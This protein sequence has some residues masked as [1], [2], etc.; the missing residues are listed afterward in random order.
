MRNI[1]RGHDAPVAAGGFK[2]RFLL[3]LSFIYAFGGFFLFLALFVV[4][5]RPLT[6]DYSA[7][8][9]ALRHLASFILPVIAFAGLVYILL[10]C[11]ATAVL[12][13]YTLHKI[14]GPLYRMERL[15]ESYLAGEPVKPAFFREGDQ[16]MALASAFNGFIGCLREDRQKWLGIMGHAERLCIQ[17]RETCR[18]EM[19][20]ALAELEIL[21][22]KYR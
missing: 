4:F 10:V 11:M 1:L 14:A 8:F 5:S 13:V 19:E 22:A 2:I 9:F 20:K 15:I 12:C 3:L 7:V 6:G 18:S 16:V 17:D 21:L